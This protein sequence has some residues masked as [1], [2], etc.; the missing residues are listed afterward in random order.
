MIN[1][2]MQMIYT[3]QTNKYDIKYHCHNLVYVIKVMHILSSL[4]LYCRIY[5]YI[6]V[7]TIIIVITVTGTKIEING[8]K[9]CQ[10]SIMY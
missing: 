4:Q 3:N 2:T 8:T 6:V 5:N 7:I 10:R 9:I 1:V